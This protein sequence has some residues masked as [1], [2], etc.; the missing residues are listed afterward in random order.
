MSRY[1]LLCALYVFCVSIKSLSINCA[2]VFLKFFLLLPCLSKS[3]RYNKYSKVKND[4]WGILRETFMYTDKITRVSFLNDNLWQ[5]KVLELTCINYSWKKTAVC[6]RKHPKMKGWLIIEYP[7][8]IDECYFNIYIG[9][10]H[11]H[12][13]TQAMTE[14]SYLIE[15]TQK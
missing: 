4:C 3:T 11:K 5:K 14:M 1:R 13:H 2:C 12:T 6:A 10:T 15:R 8:G 7:L 9:Y